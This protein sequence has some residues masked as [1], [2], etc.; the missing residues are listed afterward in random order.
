MS[1]IYVIGWCAST[2]AKDRD[3]HTRP[4]KTDVL[5]GSEICQHEKVFWIKGNLLYIIKLVIRGAVT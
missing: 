5:T 3:L 4:E 1:S 2:E